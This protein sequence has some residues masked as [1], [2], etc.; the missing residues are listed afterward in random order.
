MQ[1]NISARHGQLNDAT[2]Q[3]IAAKV[4]KLSRL[5]DRLTAVNV[6]VDLDHREMPTV[7]VRVSAE[8]AQDFVAAE[9]AANVLAALDGALHRMERQLRKH[10][11]RRTE[12]RVPGGRRLEAPLEEPGGE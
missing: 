2:Q 7:E 4:E 1:V 3:R 12:R 10:K 8:R 5:F 9:S 11:D 6:T